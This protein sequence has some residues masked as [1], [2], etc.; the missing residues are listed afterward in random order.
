M[1]LRFIAI[2]GLIAACASA[3]LA[4]QDKKPSTQPAPVTGK[5][6][7][8][9]EQVRMQLRLQDSKRLELMNLARAKLELPPISLPPP[10]TTRITARTPVSPAGAGILQ[11]QARTYSPLA[12]S[13]PDGYFALGPAGPNGSD[14]FVKLSFPAEAGKLYLLECRVRSTST[15]PIEFSREI[16]AQVTESA[17]PVDDHVIVAVRATSSVLFRVLQSKATHWWWS[18]CDIAPTS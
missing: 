3:P 7:V 18:S 11:A 1:R 2:L 13:D 15:H 4:A 16:G 12:Q 14:D 6:R 10:S 17:V 8:D 5:L 9:P